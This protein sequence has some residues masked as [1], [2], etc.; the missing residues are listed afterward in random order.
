MKQE[1]DLEDIKRITTETMIPTEEETKQKIEEDRDTT[2]KDA[3][4]NL[5]K[6]KKMNHAANKRCNQH[7]CRRIFYSG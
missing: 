3:S 7:H 6:N 4:K 5:C 1:Q 2:S